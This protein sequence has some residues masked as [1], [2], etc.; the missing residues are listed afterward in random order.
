MSEW[1]DYKL[2]ELAILITKGTTPNASEGGFS[3]EG[4][5]FIKS[6]SLNYECIIEDTKFV[7]ISE[8]TNRKLKRSILKEN[9]ILF[10]IA[11]IYLGKTGIVKKQYLPANTNQACAIIRLNHELV[12]YKFIAQ[13]FTD[14]SFINHVNSLTAQSAQPNINLKDISNLKLYLP[15]LQTQQKIANILG[16][17]DELIEVNNER[18]KILEETAQSL[19]KEWFVRFRFPNYQNTEFIKG[20]PKG[21][22]M[23]R[24]DSLYKTS[25]GAT[26]SRDNPEYYENADINWVKTGELND[27]FIFETKEKISEL[28]LKK[29]SAKLFPPYTVIFAMYGNTIGQ[30]GIITE[31]SATNQ[32]CCALLPITDDYG[33]Q[34]IFLTLYFHR[35]A[36]ISLGMG[37]AQQNV[38]QEEIKKYK[39][40]KPDK[41]LV[42]KFNEII[43]PI[44]NQ[45]EILQQQNTELR[46]I[47]D[48]LLPRL[49]SGKLVV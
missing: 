12:N 40:L 10:S 15:P 30:L 24:V 43:S 47:R 14:K 25:S 45:I 8:E 26:P 21:W 37:A 33:Y 27:S 3:S 39:I 17:Y 42:L 20:V 22:E 7:F 16:T 44:F 1:K 23:V 13:Y 35:N 6:E 2:G 49:I 28:G 46:Q 29:S 9:D 36:I 32:A 41:E 19:Y 48:R 11:G 4:V 38:S 31:P 18:I 5:K 34:F